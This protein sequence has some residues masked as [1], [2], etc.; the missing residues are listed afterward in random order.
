M[1][2][3]DDLVEQVESVIIDEER[4]LAPIR[5]T[6]TKAGVKKKTSDHILTY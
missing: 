6:P 4:E 5:I 3:S 1:F 2:E